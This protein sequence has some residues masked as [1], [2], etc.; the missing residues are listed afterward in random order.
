MAGNTV[1]ERRQALAAFMQT[2][3]RA[4]EWGLGRSKPSDAPQLIQQYDQIS[5]ALAAGDKISL[6]DN[7]Q[8][9]L[10]LTNAGFMDFM[11]PKLRGLDSLQQIAEAL[12]CAATLTGRK[13]LELTPGEV[14]QMQLAPLSWRRFDSPRLAC[15][16]HLIR[17]HG[18][19]LSFVTPTGRKLRHLYRETRRQF[20]EQLVG[21]HSNR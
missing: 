20:I 11:D 8:L 17:K 18:R 6:T 14:K 5:E 10:M 19:F 2:H 9:L 16:R 21:A 13:M 12:H 4:V 1:A 15:L 3:R 7:T